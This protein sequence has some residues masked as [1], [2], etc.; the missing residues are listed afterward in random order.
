ML[1]LS[2]QLKSYFESA[3]KQAFPNEFSY[4]KAKNINI[5]I[6]VNKAS[7]PEFGDFQVNSALILSKVFKKNPRII[8]EK[9]VAKL[10]SNA[11][12][13]EICSEPKI[14]GPGFIN[15]KVNDS[16]LQNE[17]NQILQDKKLGIVPIINDKI[18][19]NNTV[20]VDFSSPNIAKEM[21]VGHLRSTIIGDCLSRVFELRGFNVIRINHIGDWGTQ[22]GMLIRYIK[23][24][25]PS[26]ISNPLNI[27]IADL[28][29]FYK[30]AKL[31][32]DTDSDFKLKSRQ[33]VIK[34]QH[35][36][37][38][39][40]KIWEILC[41]YSRK[42]FNKIYKRLNIRI[43][44]RGESFYNKFLENIV[45][46]LELKDL[47]L[48]DNGAKCVF[49]NDIKNR[50]G[51]SLPLIIQKRDG[52]FNYATTDLAAIK[53]RFAPPPKGD[54]ATKIFYVTDSGQANH[55]SG[56]FEVANKAKWI[57]PNCQVKH[58]PFGL[59]QGLD[60]KKFKTRSGD[61]IKLKDLLDEAVQR[62][63][64]DLLRRIK[65]EGRNETDEFINNVSTTVGI[66]SV[67]YADLS[68]N[69]ISNYQF[70]F[71]KM[72]ALQGNTAPYILYTIVRIAGIK[73]R[74]GDF[75]DNEFSLKNLD[76]IEKVLI[77]E[78]LKFDEIINEV[79]RDLLPNRLCNYLFD[80]SQIFNR[81]YDQIPIL[82]ANE[83]QKTNRLTLCKL[84]L[85]TLQ[86][87]LELLG[88]PSLERM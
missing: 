85:K 66:A 26:I 34:L 42:E 81:F 78:L 75:A 57:P 12:F 59:V 32:F 35:G 63:K 70:S 88:I 6:Q 54:G 51:N 45:N 10:L 11:N 5:D 53:Y 80:L 40:L 44:E 9:I 76:E 29:D 67:K 47:V 55:F 18:N 20:V 19:F 72:L 7:K 83:P 16:R 43:T 46:E 30:K 74:G 56:I 60:G 27:D 14:A 79:E 64:E 1:K 22:F 61:T 3:L 17:V 25:E 33:E 68:Q 13:K 38:T 21:H 48:L 50:E 71:D 65:D 24:F 52:G 84:T 49:L 23:D 82:K 73:R 77:R 39:N 8:A 31:K 2:R 15:I 62:A 87:G 37:N 58:V 41:K 4:A 86:L 69:R 28:M 36:D